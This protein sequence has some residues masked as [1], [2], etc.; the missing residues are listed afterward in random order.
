[1]LRALP[2]RTSEGA[3]LLVLPDA[4]PQERGQRDR[5][6]ELLGGTTL[7]GSAQEIPVRA[8]GT[9][10]GERALA[11]LG[12][13]A[14][15]V[16]RFWR[17]ILI[18]L[19]AA[20]ASF[21]LL[22]GLVARV[23]LSLRLRKRERILEGPLLE[24]LE[25][26]RERAGLRRRV[27]L[28]VSKRVSTA[29]AFGL[30]RTEICLPRR[31]ATD[32][33]PAELRSMMAHELAHGLRGDP[34]WLALLHLIESVLFF[35]P[36]NRLARRKVQETAEL[37][38][39]DLALRWGGERLA[40]A[41]CLTEVA[42]WLLRRPAAG[43]P[44]AGMA[45]SRSSLGRRIERLLDERVCPTPERRHR[46][47]VAVASIA[48]VLLALSLPGLGAPENEL[49]VAPSASPAPEAEIAPAPRVAPVPAPVPVPVPE[50]ALEV[51][52]VAPLVTHPT[53]HDSL[54]RLDSELRLLDHEVGELRAE[55]E[56]GLLLERFGAELESIEQRL[57]KLNER[58]R[59][60]NQILPRLL[61]GSPHQTGAPD[62]PTSIRFPRK[63]GKR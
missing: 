19:W 25:E 61:A 5:R 38:C 8:S 39:D 33:S 1:V 34:R 54:E 62:S 12:G 27:R 21:L 53:L 24:T 9:P 52:P 41:S 26:L 32:L 55:L 3:R 44:V 16:G 28:S 57:R 4:P 48:P 37:I 56:D 13:L 15:Q 6:A 47:F 2:V 42:Q 63:E 23:R 10:R 11:F 18:G 51:V 29:L 43:L 46:W 7:A 17:E 30:V 45:P 35:Q 14:R 58:G 40:L 31:V 36:L 60:V 22:R 59:R 50:L 49:A 20:G